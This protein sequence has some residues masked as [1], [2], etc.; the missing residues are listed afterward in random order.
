[1]FGFAGLDR[2]GVEIYAGDKVKDE[3]GIE[4]EV[5]YERNQKGACFYLRS[6]SIK[7]LIVKDLGRKT[8]IPQE[9][10]VL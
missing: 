9:V 1:M 7:G 4:Y 10:E 3:D 2:K 5:T 8:F 6:D